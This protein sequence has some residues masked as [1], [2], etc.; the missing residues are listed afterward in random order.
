MVTESPKDATCKCAPKLT[1]YEKMVGQYSEDDVKMMND[2][3][4]Y[5]INSKP[6]KDFGDVMWIKNCYNEDVY[7]RS[8]EPLY[9]DFHSHETSLTDVE[10]MSFKRYM[11]A[12]VYLNLLKSDFIVKEG[13]D[14]SFAMLPP[15][16]YDRFLTWCWWRSRWDTC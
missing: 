1:P 14:Y 5:I 4:E 13:K 2:V 12:K 10:C 8:Q 9:N 7:K 16:R 15:C 6:E 3:H 11:N